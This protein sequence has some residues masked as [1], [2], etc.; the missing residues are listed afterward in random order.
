MDTGIE[1]NIHRSDTVDG[2]KIRARDTKSYPVDGCRDVMPTF[3]KIHRK[4]ARYLATRF[5]REL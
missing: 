2:T 5:L 4:D 1:E 3:D